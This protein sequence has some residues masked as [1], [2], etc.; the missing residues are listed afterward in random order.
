MI[1]LLDTSSDV[2]FVLVCHGQE[3]AKPKGKYH[4]LPVDLCSCLATIFFCGGVSA[5]PQSCC[6]L[7]TE[8]KQIRKEPEH[9][10]ESISPSRPESAVA[11]PQK[12]WTKQ[13]WRWKSVDLCLGC[14]HNLT[15]TCKDARMDGWMDELRCVIHKDFHGL[16]RQTNLSCR[17]GYHLPHSQLT[18]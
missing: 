14:H 6:R 4:K 10:G 3:R 2:S 13:S 18:E 5:L 7:H 1:I 16:F 17:H 8:K 15:W 11:S 12:T 9:A